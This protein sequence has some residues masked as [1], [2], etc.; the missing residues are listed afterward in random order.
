MDNV[1]LNELKNTNNECATRE[2]DTVEEEFD[3][4]FPESTPAAFKQ[5]DPRLVGC[6]GDCGSQFSKFIDHCV[7]RKVNSCLYILIIK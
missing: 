5:F 4:Q 6:N 2:T 7:Y 1:L 3:I